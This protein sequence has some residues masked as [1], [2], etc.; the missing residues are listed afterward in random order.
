M[1]ELQAA[2]GL[3]QL[4]KLKKII[5]ENRK[6]YIQLEKLNTLFNKRYIFKDTIPSFDTFV[7][8]VKEKK[9]MKQ[10]LEI[11]KKNNIGTKNLPG[12]LRWHFAGEWKH[13]FNKKLIK[14]I[15]NCKIKL[16]KCIAIPILLKKNISFY[17]KIANDIIKSN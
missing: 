12:A 13:I 16:E 5:K 6:R 17:K 7:F 15:K 4:T 3:V 9:Q 8:E 1:T 2:V 11:L 14:Q 10:I